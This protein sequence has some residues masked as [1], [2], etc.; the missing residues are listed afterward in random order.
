MTDKWIGNIKES[1]HTEI[2][3]D[4]GGKFSLLPCDGN[5]F[6]TVNRPKLYAVLGSGYLPNIPTKDSSAP[7]KI[8]ADPLA[9]LSY[10]R[11]KNVVAFLNPGGETGTWYFGDGNTSTMIDPLNEY[12]VHGRYFGSFNSHFLEVDIPPYHPPVSD[13]VATIDELTINCSGSSSS[14]LYPPLTYSYDF[15]DG[16]VLTG[17]DVQHTFT[18]TGDHNVTLTIVDDNNEWSRTTK[19]FFLNDTPVANFSFS[20]NLLELT[21]T[22]TSTDVDGITQSTWNFGDGEISYSSNPVHTYDTPGTYT[23]SLVVKDVYFLESEIYS[24]E[25]QVSD[26]WITGPDLLPADVAACD[27]DAQGITGGTGALINYDAGICA[28]NATQSYGRY[29]ITV[30]TLGLEVGVRYLFRALVKVDS[31]TT[32]AA[33]IRSFTCGDAITTPLLKD[34]AWHEYEVP[35]DCTSTTGEIRISCNGNMEIDSMLCAK[36]L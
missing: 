3:S 35:F 5:S 26:T 21:F 22:N 2:T 24:E 27:G 23:V 12:A 7:F 29:F 25:I 8:F 4:N 16:T 19:S 30:D 6:D 36:I 18:T 34:D 9:L 31:A 1:P 33:D 20:R 28:F 11:D 32:T 13:Y 14:T 10:S 17:E 15:G